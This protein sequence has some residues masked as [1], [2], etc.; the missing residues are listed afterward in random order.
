MSEDG[1]APLAGSR[2]IPAATRNI[3]M[4]PVATFPPSRRRAR[5]NLPA[6]AVLLA[7]GTA[8]AHGQD[9]EA[10]W[11]PP[12]LPEGLDWTF[13]FDAT[14]GG[15]GFGNSL[16]TNPRPDQPSGDLGANWVEGSMKP[17]MSAEYGLAESAQLFG[18]LSVVGEGTYRSSPTLVGGDAGSFDLEDAYVGWRSGNRFES[19]GENALEFT[20]GRSR[21]RLGN[22]MLLW[23]G[24]SEG[25]S[26]GGY[27]TNARQ[28]FEMAAIGRFKPGNHTLEGFY[29][30]K[31]ELPESDADTA[32]WG[33]NYE[34]AFGDDTTLGAT[35]LKFSADPALQPQRDG[36]EVYNLRAYTAP[37]QN[38]ALSFELEYAKED[39][40]VALDSAAWTALAAYQL[41]MTWQPKVSYRYAL[42]EGDDPA[43]AT[44]EAFDSLLTG[45]S[46]WGAWWQ[47]EIA[48]EYFV[49]NSNLVSHQFRVHAT[50]SDAIGTGLILYDFLLDR[51]ATP[52]ASDDIARELDWYMDW[53]VNDNFVVSFVAALADPGQAVEESSG[54]TD[55]FMYGMVF[56]AYSF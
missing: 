1:R 37:F 9:D 28:A 34:Y 47:G 50:P 25:G 23:D 46:D 19:F 14:L 56:A 13:N 54:R 36:L 4:P 7:L 42:F 8:T 24:V 55:T 20:L 6:V 49:S 16:Y 33:L 12:G 38:K 51:T 26:R 44:N 31:D 17:A 52:G 22:G 53:S 18:A 43:T 15:F 32:L 41:E 21:Y 10:E 2:V 30:E 40:G 39:N 29:L 27:W 5:R 45:F 3:D 35:Y 11:V 48:G